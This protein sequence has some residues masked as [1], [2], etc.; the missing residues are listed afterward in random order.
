MIISI[1]ERRG[2]RKKAEEDS[3]ED[4]QEWILTAQRTVWYCRCYCCLFFRGVFAAEQRALL[5]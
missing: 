1:V 5:A 4:I 2:D 3:R